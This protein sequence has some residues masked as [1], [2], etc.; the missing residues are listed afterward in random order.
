MCFLTQQLDVN[1]KQAVA[2][3]Q[4]NF[5]ISTRVNVKNPGCDAEALMQHFP[6]EVF[7]DVMAYFASSASCVSEPYILILIDAFEWLTCIQ[8][9][10]YWSEQ[11][12]EYRIACHVNWEAASNFIAS[13]VGTVSEYSTHRLM[14]RAALIDVDK[15]LP[16]ECQWRLVNIKKKWADIEANLSKCRK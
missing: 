10:E 9:G 2:C 15:G 12:E 5:A 11:P 4:A 14:R 13:T 8:R 3:F 1:D 6:S 7:N 16:L